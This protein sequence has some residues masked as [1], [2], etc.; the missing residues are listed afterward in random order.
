[1][2]HW[3]RVL[4]QDGLFERNGTPDYIHF[5]LSRVAR[6]VEAMEPYQFRTDTFD[7]IADALS[8]CTAGCDTG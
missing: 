5:G 8:E 1:M 7:E 2:E 6:I 3:V 4:L